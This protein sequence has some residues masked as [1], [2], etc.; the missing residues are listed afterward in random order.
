MTAILRIRVDRSNGG[1]E[2]AVESPDRFS[3]PAPRAQSASLDARQPIP[4]P[5]EYR[6]VRQSRQRNPNA[7][8]VIRLAP[9]VQ[10]NQLGRGQ[11]ARRLHCSKS[12][13]RGDG[14][15]A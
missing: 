4:R 10:A 1:W 5:K 15:A 7:D 8:A 6:G 2:F 3:R 13:K 11:S 9:A 12:N 14:D